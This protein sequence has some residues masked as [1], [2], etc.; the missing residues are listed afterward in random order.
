[1]ILPACG[2]AKLDHPRGVIQPN[3]FTARACA[4]V[5]AANIAKRSQI[6]GGAPTYFPRGESADGRPFPR[7]GFVCSSETIWRGR[8]AQAAGVIIDGGRARWSIL[9]ATRSTPSSCGTASRRASTS[10]GRMRAVRTRW[11]SRI[12]GRLPIFRQGRSCRSGFCRKS[13]ASLHF[14]VRWACSAEYSPSNSL[15]DHFKKT[16]AT[17]AVSSG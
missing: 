16:M 2:V 3:R 4:V 15:R 17:V 6:R 8:T 12:S 1:M 11:F 13:R 5:W 7:G 9:K 14:R 10:A